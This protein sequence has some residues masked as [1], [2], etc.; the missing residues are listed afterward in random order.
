[1]SCDATR[2]GLTV[3]PVNT[4]WVPFSSAALVTGALSLFAGAVLLPSGESTTETLRMVQDHDGRWFAVSI[5]FFL[6]GVGILVG[7][8]SLLMLFPG[9]GRRWGFAGVGAMAIAC[10][11]TAGYAMLLVFFRAL[12]LEDAIKVSAMDR[13]TADPGL[14]GFL[15]SWIATF[16]LGELLL[17][18]AVLR[19]RTVPRWM[20]ALLVLH[21]ALLPVS[22]LLPEQLSTFT[23]VT[24]A[25]A[26][27]GM[28][29]SANSEAGRLFTVTAPARPARL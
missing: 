9:R 11:G 26:F 10:A 18:I 8:P 20:P 14:T 27:S 2:P 3:S 15:Y 16:Y 23:V 5:L 6:A 25:L 28:A 13:V 19:A 21:V 4:Q 24:T 7:L 17:A 12:V 1:M 29:I 22:S